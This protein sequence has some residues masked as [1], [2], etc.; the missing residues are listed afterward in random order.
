VH[1]RRGPVNHG[2]LDNFIF[3]HYFSFTSVCHFLPHNGDNQNL[4]LATAIESGRCD[5][6]SRKSYAGKG[7]QISSS[8]R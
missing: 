2:G 7:K 6:L 5:I 3:I 8:I 4:P 1:A